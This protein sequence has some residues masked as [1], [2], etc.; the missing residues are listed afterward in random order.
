MKTKLGMKAK[1]W[2]ANTLAYYDMTTITVIN[3]FIVQ[4]PGSSSHLDSN[5]KTQDQQL[6]VLPLS[7]C[8]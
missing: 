5:P 3:S 1:Q 2:L 6:S 7:Y 8:H 4:A